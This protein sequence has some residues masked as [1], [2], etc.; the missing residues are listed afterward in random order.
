MFQQTPSKHQ[1]SA[2]QSRRHAL[3]NGAHPLPCLPSTC[4]SRSSCLVI[5]ATLHV[6]ENGTEKE[7]GPSPHFHPQNIR[8]ARCA[9]CRRSSC[10]DCPGLRPSTCPCGRPHLRPSGPGIPCGTGTPAPDP[11]PASGHSSSATRASAGAKVSAA[12]RPTTCIASPEQLELPGLEICYMTTKLAM[13]TR[14]CQCATLQPR[15]LCVRKPVGN[16][17]RG[18]MLG[19]R[20]A[21]A[22]R[23]R[24]TPPPHPGARRDHRT[25]VDR[26]GYMA[27]SA[28]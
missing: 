5:H 23:W 25:H 24:A 28:T 14:S 7:A 11:C 2:Q 4:V 18:W 9:W 26:R 20:G 16:C 3:G 10:P 13:A 19:P 21:P 12:R 15:R 17:R 1:P 22:N 27:S 6:P 8:H